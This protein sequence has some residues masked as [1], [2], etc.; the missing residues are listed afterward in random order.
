MARRKKKTYDD[1]DGRTIANMNVDGMPWY[2]PSARQQ[3]LRTDDGPEKDG[4][5]KR[6]EPLELTK[7]ESRAM[8]WGMIKAAL[9]ICGIFILAALLFIL[10]CLFVWLK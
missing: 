6:E 3:R 1:D 2:Q 4:S 8:Y 5:A 9:L 10:F 7:E